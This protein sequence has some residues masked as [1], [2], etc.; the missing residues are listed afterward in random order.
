MTPS[1]RKRSRDDTEIAPPSKKVRLQS[2]DQILQKNSHWMKV[3]LPRQQHDDVVGTAPG[4]DAAAK[5][6]LQKA[7][8][9]VE[10]DSRRETLTKLATPAELPELDTEKG[11]NR[12]AQKYAALIRMNSAAPGKKRKSNDIE[13]P[14]SEEQGRATKKHK[15]STSESDGRLSR[16]ASMTPLPSVRTKEKTKSPPSTATKTAESPESRVD[17]STSESTPS[18]PR[19]SAKPEKR[20][21]IKKQPFPAAKKKLDFY[22]KRV[23]L[24]AEETEKAE[25]KR[26]G[27]RIMREPT[28]YSRRRATERK[29]QVNEALMPESKRKQPLGSASASSNRK[30][31]LPA[32]SERKVR[33]KSPASDTDDES[34]ENRPSTSSARPARPRNESGGSSDSQASSTGAFKQPDP[35]LEAIRRKYRARMSDGSIP[36]RRLS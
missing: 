32:R 2:T 35:R 27:E 12:L 19:P 15:S 29:K 22:I 10:L 34:T 30:P 28:A 24:T 26:T 3:K 25:L 36:N 20:P 16:R 7:S 4:V 11:L 31:L 8:D 6:T 5:S 13:E 9:K 18:A 21:A 1:S 14:S 17:K 33:Q 23:P